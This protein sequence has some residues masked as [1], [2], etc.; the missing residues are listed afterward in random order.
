[1]GRDA[2]RRRGTTTLE[3]PA[4]TQE[5]SGQRAASRLKRVRSAFTQKVRLV[6]RRNL[7]VDAV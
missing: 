5:Q 1:V 6:V 2:V 4:R 3:A 7:G